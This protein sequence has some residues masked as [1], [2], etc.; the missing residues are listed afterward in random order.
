MKKLLL[1]IFLLVTISPL[2]AQAT[3]KVFTEKDF[4]GKWK[5]VT[6]SVNNV[7][8]DVASGKATVDEVYGK[9]IKPEV[10]AG[11]KEGME[12]E[13]ADYTDDYLEVKGKNFSMFVDDKTQ[14]GS[15][16]ITRDKKNNQVVVAT[17]KDS[18][19]STVPVIVKDGKIVIKQK[20]TGK[21]FTFD[22]DE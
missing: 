1:S 22:K 13:A 10:A 7:S 16:K 18:S 21:I 6:Y 5:L 3:A 9:T 12:R 19:K 8:L 2:W 15:F 4:Q 20:Y 14:K 17:F 11:L